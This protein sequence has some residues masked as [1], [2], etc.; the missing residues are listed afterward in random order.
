[1][2]L[3]Q[4]VGTAIAVVVFFVIYQQF[5]NYLIAPKVFAS[6]VSLSPITVFLCVML[7]GAIG[8]LVGVI[9]ALPIAAAMKVVFRHAFRNQLAVIEDREVPAALAPP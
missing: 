6:A 5:E 4:S 7:G 3:T 1:M 8:G 2:A 9:M